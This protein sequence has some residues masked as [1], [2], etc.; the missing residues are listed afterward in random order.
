MR[1]PKA[2]RPVQ[3]APVRRPARRF[4]WPA[5]LLSATT[6]ATGL[7]GCGDQTPMMMMMN[8]PADPG[9]PVCSASM[10]APQVPTV[11]MKVPGA[12]ACLSPAPEE[13]GGAPVLDLRPGEPL[14]VP[15]Y[16]TIGPA[17][18]LATGGTI[19]RRGVD[20]LLPL[21]WTKIPEAARG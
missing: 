3:I 4:G 11:S 10:L 14:T 5:L 20:V 8:P 1:T 12:S 15:G 13:T 21:D 6:G 17:V 2:H 7:L 19:G 9:L 16:V 18:E